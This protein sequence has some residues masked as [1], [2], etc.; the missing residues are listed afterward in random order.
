MAT[1][2]ALFA[3]ALVPVLAPGARAF[4]LVPADA[5]TSRA[6]ADRAA[7]CSAGAEHARLR[8]ELVSALARAGGEAEAV[9]AVEAALGSCPWCGCGLA[10]PA[11]AG[12]AVPSR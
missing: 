1:R 7:A 12:E 5:E 9:A 10:T 3:A 8:A 6:V 11:D 4:R 2:R